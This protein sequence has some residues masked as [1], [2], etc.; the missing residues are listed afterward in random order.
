MQGGEVLGSM[1]DM[2]EKR[3]MALIAQRQ[4]ELEA[5]Q[6][7]EALEMQKELQKQ[8]IA[9]SK[10]ESEAKAKAQENKR[11]F[12]EGIASGQME[13]TGQQIPTGQRLPVGGTMQIGQSIEPNLLRQGQSLQMDPEVANDATMPEMTQ[14]MRRRDLDLE[15]MSRLGLETD[16]LSPNDLLD[17]KKMG[18]GLTYEQRL[19][20]LK[21]GDA[22]KMERERLKAGLR[23]QDLEIKRGALGLKTRDQGREFAKED[24]QLEASIDALTMKSD[25][26]KDIRESVA[27]I[28]DNEGLWANAG[29]GQKLSIMP[30]SSAKDIKVELDYA[31]KSLLPSA[32]KEAKEAGATFGAMT[33]AEWKNLEYSLANLDPNQSPENYRANVGRIL[34]QVDNVLTMSAK[35]IARATKRIESNNSIEPNRQPAKITPKAES[36]RSKYEY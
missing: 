3:K 33:E 21:T 17:Y 29:W 10:A 2:I 16:Q 26:F 12:Q 23:Q 13:P 28:Y 25:K 9:S 1:R 14:E 5:Q 20:L 31:V 11:K 8:Q 15:E 34:K 7:A 18:N 24:S 27:N 6:K 30:A 22:S 4:A 19:D 32:V 35:D 36:L